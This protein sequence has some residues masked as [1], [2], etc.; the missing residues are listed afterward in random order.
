MHK[1]ENKE[2]KTLNPQ[3]YFSGTEHPDSYDGCII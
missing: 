3:W 2:E 1:V